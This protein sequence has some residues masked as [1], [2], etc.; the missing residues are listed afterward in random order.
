MNKPF[1]P[2][3]RYVLRHI[4]QV[5]TETLDMALALEQAGIYN[6]VDLCMFSNWEI[7]NFNI[8]RKPLKPIYL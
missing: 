1:A 5:D 6:G 2:V 8:K 7:D 3:V 4:L